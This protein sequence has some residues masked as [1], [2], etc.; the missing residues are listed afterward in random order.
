MAQPELSRYWTRQKVEGPFGSRMLHGGAFDVDA[1]EIRYG[2][3]CVLALQSCYEA[4]NDKR[5]AELAVEDLGGTVSQEILDAV[6]Q[7]DEAFRSVTGFTFDELQNARD[8]ARVEVIR[9]TID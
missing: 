1:F 7:A 6:N 3:A 2:N 9:E 8:H 4:R 5:A